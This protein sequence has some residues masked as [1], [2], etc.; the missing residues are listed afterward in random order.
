MND[1]FTCGTCYQEATR[2]P[3]VGSELDGT[4]LSV[5]KFG[6]FI[7]VS[8]NRDGLLHISK[9]GTGTRVDRMEDVLSIGDTVRVRIEFIDSNGK[10]SLSLP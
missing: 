1:R 4:V 2:V 5:T 7:R 3:D 9:L 6:A 10:I 8:P